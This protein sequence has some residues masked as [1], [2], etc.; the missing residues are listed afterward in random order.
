MT[1]P[2]KK[3]SIGEL[4][5]SVF[6]VVKIV[7]FFVTFITGCATITFKISRMEDKFVSMTERID[8]YYEE[9]NEQIDI[10]EKKVANNETKINDVDKR[11]TVL[12]S[13]R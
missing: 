4:T 2:D 13:K 3:V 11:V 9:S 8:Q 7:G 12:E 10:I 5:F 1:I 6:D